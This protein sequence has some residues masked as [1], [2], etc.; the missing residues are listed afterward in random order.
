[1]KELDTMLFDPWLKLCY[2]YAE[3]NHFTQYALRLVTA[4][5]PLDCCVLR[6]NCNIEYVLCQLIQNILFIYALN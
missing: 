1:M 2:F 5:N 6:V 3:N 4:L